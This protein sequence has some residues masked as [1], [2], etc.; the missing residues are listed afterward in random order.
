MIANKTPIRGKL[1]LRS[2]DK[3][4]CDFCQNYYCKTSFLVGCI[5]ERPLRQVLRPK[6]DALDVT[7]NGQP[8]RCNFT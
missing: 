4:R 6:Y 1:N 8:L 7:L 5:V 2:P 3:L